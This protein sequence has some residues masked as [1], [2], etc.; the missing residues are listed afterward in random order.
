[1]KFEEELEKKW[2]SVN[3]T[4]AKVTSLAETIN[5]VPQTLGKLLREATTQYEKKIEAT[6]ASSRR[7]LNVHLKSLEDGSTG[8]AKK[9]GTTIEK[10]MKE[11]TGI[12]IKRQ[13]ELDEAI[14]SRSNAL[15]NTVTDKVKEIADIVSKQIE[16]LKSESLNAQALTAKTISSNTAQIEL[17]L[18]NVHNDMKQALEATCESLNATVESKCKGNEDIT[19]NV[20]SETSKA[21]TELKEKLRSSIATEKEQLAQICESAASELKQIT[22]EYTKQLYEITS[23]LTNSFNGIV[24]DASE[25]YK[26]EAETT[27]TALV[28]L[29]SQHIKSY[30]E[31]V[32]KILVELNS[33]LT[34]HLEDCTALTQNF[35]NRFNELLTQ[36]QNKYEAASNRM[37]QGLTTA[38]DQDEAALNSSSNKM[39][40]EFTDNTAKA[41]KEAS[42]T[43]N[44]MR[45]A[46]AEIID[47]QQIS[48]DKTWH[49]VTKRAILEHVRDMVKR[50]KSTVTIVVPNIEEAPLK[51]VK[52]ISRTIRIQI[53]AGVD[54][55]LHK[56]L[57][58]E[59]YMQGNVRIWSLTEKDY[60]SCTRDAEEVLVA[61]VA[62]KDTDCVATVSVEENYVKLYHKFIGPMWMASSREIK[63]KTLG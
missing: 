11:L 32:D 62:R 24:N 56:K 23:S 34:K 12:S 53:I 49:Y 39:L 25:A 15:E 41:S 58:K 51:E 8:T 36:H 59:L 9:W 61:P 63:E 44:L 18:K 17:H 35:G 60:I 1:M 42:S 4:I 38:I 31:A 28:A 20:I 30:K 29:L 55:N 6:V 10:T 52:E 21:V 3:G 27:K 47:T 50:T 22:S 19:A 14:T 43:E 5:V 40:K 57:L 33:T 13:A 46:W 16:A 7:L 26:K 37:V 48:A 45:A 54:E 2:G